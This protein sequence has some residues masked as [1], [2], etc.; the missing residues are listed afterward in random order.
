MIIFS[1]NILQIIFFPIIFF[2]AFVR[3]IFNKENFTSFSQKF[4]CNYNFSQFGNFDYLIHFASIGELNSINYL[5]ENLSSKKVLLTCS[6]LSSYNLAKQKYQNY[7]V[8][9][10]PLDFRW[11]INKFLNH[12]K[13]KKIIWIDSEIWPNWLFISN[14]KKIKKYIS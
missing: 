10:L 5:I 7:S 14:N 2:I 3:I 1:Y 13:I 12:I 8:I 9:F 6:T 11:N 4:L